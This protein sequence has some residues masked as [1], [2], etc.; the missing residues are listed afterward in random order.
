MV[1]FRVQVVMIIPV[2]NLYR[3]LVERFKGL[4]VS[5]LIEQ[6]EPHFAERV[7]RLE[8]GENKGVVFE[9]I[10]DCFRNFMRKP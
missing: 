4:Y 8:A 10:S 9:R 1:I 3:I 5:F 7:K 2:V 6:G